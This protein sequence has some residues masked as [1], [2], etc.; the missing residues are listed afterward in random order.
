MPSDRPP[1]TKIADC[2]FVSLSLSLCLSVLWLC[3]SLSLSLSIALY[4]SLSHSCSHLLSTLS[5]QLVYPYLDQ[6]PLYW[7]L[8]LSTAPFVLHEIFIVRV[9]LL[10]AGSRWA[11]APKALKS[12]NQ[13]INQS[14]K[15][16]T[17][18]SIDQSSNQ[19]VNRS[20]HLAISCR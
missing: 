15:Q 10:L 16:S 3:C 18:R 4:L 17:S 14:I 11:V 20:I 9:S 5:S 8:S 6:S 19:W 7:D 12:I 13:S 2:L 1:K